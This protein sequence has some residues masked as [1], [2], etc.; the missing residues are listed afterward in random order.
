ML[1]TFTHHNYIEPLVVTRGSPQINTDK[2][3]ASVACLFSMNMFVPSHCWCIHD[4]K[5][6]KSTY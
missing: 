4:D 3:L 1:I 2:L 5:L 6:Q